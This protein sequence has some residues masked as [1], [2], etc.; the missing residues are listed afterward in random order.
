LLE[1]RGWTDSATLP[2]AWHELARLT[3]SPEL[4]ARTCVEQAVRQGASTI[5]VAGFGKNGR[6]L[7]AALGARDRVMPWSIRDD[8]LGAT[9]GPALPARLEPMRARIGSDAAVI[10]S[11]ERDEALVSALVSVGVTRLVRWKQVLADL[12]TIERGALCSPP[13]AGTPLDRQELRCA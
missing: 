13:S 10:I 3:V 12:A 8:A 2:A 4:V 11:P 5:V 6:R 7:A 1:Q 9:R